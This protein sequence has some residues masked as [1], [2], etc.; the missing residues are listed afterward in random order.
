MKKG[1]LLL[2]FLPF[3]FS[4]CSKNAVDLRDDYVGSWSSNGVGSMS[5]TYNGSVIANMP[6]DT[7]GT[8]MLTKVGTDQLSF[9]GMTATLQGSKLIIPTKTQT[10]ISDGMTMQETQTYTASATKGLITVIA[11]TSGN[12]S[13]PDGTKGTI[14]GSITYTYLKK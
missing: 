3:M 8:V 5:L 2:L 10:Q 4:S 11:D 7:T 1:F 6:T 13:T 12:W 14:S 9:D